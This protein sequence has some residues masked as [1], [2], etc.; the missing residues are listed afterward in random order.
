[1]AKAKTQV[2][3]ITPELPTVDALSKLDQEI[4]DLGRIV[5][6]PYKTNGNVAGFPDVKTCMDISTLIK[7]YSS[8][9][10]REA[11]YNKAAET[12]GLKS[13]PVFT[14]G[15]TAEDWKHDIQLRIDIIQHEGKLNKLKE[16]KKRMSEFLSK[17]D[18]KNILLQEMTDFLSK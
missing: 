16:F 17:E 7:M 11:S 6:T 1:M 8:V 3:L 2:A 12:L 13:Y 4:Q 18:Q 9:S 10:N 15:G 14:E 5:D